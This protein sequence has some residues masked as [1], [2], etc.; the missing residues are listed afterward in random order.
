M[1][2]FSFQHFMKPLGSNIFANYLSHLKKTWR[3]ARFDPRS[4]GV[5]FLRSKRSSIWACVNIITIEILSF[6]RNFFV[7]NFE[8]VYPHQNIVN[9]GEVCDG[10]DYIAEDSGLLVRGFNPGRGKKLQEYFFL[11]F[12]WLLWNLWDLPLSI[13]RIDA[14][15]HGNK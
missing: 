14:N 11:V 8:Q 15:R 6:V 7:T 1:T 2:R 12:A 5:K 13:Q 3:T 4:L 9:W 10:S